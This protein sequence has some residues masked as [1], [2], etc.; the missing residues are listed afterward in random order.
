MPV[1][2]HLV[3]RRGLGNG[4]DANRANAVPIEQ[5]ARSR[6][7]SLTRAVLRCLCGRWNSLFAHSLLTG[8]SLVSTVRVLPV[9][10]VRRNTLCE[11]CHGSDVA[12]DRVRRRV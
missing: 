6:E 9:S 5:I 3:G 11:P 8:V 7:N 1:E 10:N 2:R 4:V 12:P